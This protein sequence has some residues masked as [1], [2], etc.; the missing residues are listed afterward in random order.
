MPGC[1]FY[2]RCTQRV[3]LCKSSSPA[4]QPVNS[5]REVACHLGGVVTLLS[6]SGMN[7]CYRLPDGGMLDAVKDVCLDISEGEVL[8]IVGQTGS[9]KSTLAHMLAGVMGSGVGRSI[10]KE[11]G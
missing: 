3:D 2:S 6:A 10:S 1:P 8:A 4:L 9:G 11:T 7:Y 5:E